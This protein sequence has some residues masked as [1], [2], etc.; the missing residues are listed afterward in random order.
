MPKVKSKEKLKKKNSENIKAKKAVVKQK[1]KKKNNENSRA[2][3]KVLNKQKCKNKNNEN[4]KANKTVLHKTKS[5]KSKITKKKTEKQYTTESLKKALDMIG[6]GQTIRQAA[7]NFD[8]PKSTLY[9]KLKNFSPLEC[10]KGPKTVLSE[11]E[12][13]DIVKWILYCAERGFPVSKSQLLDS[14][15]KFLS[16]SKKENPFKNNR[17]S[18]HWYHAFMRRH[19][20]ISQRTAQ[21]LTTTRASV[22][23]DDIRKWFANVKEYFEKKNLLEIGPERVFNMDESSF[24]LVPKDNSVL[25]KKGARSVYQIV[26]SNE[27][28]CLTVLFGAAASGT[29]PPPM[30]LFDLKTTPKKNVLDKIPKGWGVGNTERGWM[31][32]E[33]FFSYIANVFFKWLKQNNY[34]FPVILYLDGHSSHLTLPLCK[35]CQE[36]QIELVALYPNATHILQPLDV[37]LFHPLKECYRRILRQWRIDNDVVE[38]KKSMFGPILKLTL[39]SIDLTESIVSGFRCCGL[40]PFDSNAVNYSIMNKE[41]K[42]NIVTPSSEVTINNEKENSENENMRLLRLFESTIIPDVLD[43]F[44]ENEMNETWNGELTLQGLFKSWRQM[45]KLTGIHLNIFIYTHK[46]A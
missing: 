9:C 31:T 10:R 25:A 38:V 29:M 13:N 35:F 2:N 27:K 46:Y 39:D 1:L 5:I 22:T 19:P 26:G 12:E 7:R 43:A 24:M 40:F 28:A 36:N 11:E 17:P 30:I 44:K 34:T 45:K 6:K 14:V 20:N 4:T 37:A 3:K 15:Q 8:V 18:K 23:E 33:S 21:N 41:K 32:S 16:T 42:K